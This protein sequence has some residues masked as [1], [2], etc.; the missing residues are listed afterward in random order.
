VSNALQSIQADPAS[1]LG[2]GENSEPHV[3]VLGAGLGGM[4]AAIALRRRGWRVTVIEKE[5]SPWHRVGESFD[6]ETPV[7]LEQLGLN[8]EELRE[9]DVLALKPAVI[10]WSD[11]SHRWNEAWLIPDPRYFRLIRR[12]PNTYHGNRHQLDHLLS[13]MMQAE[14]CRLVTERVRKVHMQGQTVEK[15]ELEGGEQLQAPFYIDASGRARLIMRAA[16]VRTTAQGEKMVSLWRRQRHHYD[17]KGTRLYLVDVGEQVFWT[18]N[19]HVG[20]EITDIGMVLPATLYRSLAS[21]GLE[22]NGDG[23]DTKEAEDVYWKLLEKVKL[24]SDFADQS[25]TAGPLQ[26]CSFQN[27]MA[28]RAAGDNWLAVGEAAYVID[29]ISSGGTTIALRSGKFAARILDEALSKG[30]TQVPERDRHFFH[31]RLSLQV[32]F[33]NSALDDLFRFRRLGYR[34]GMPIYVRLLTWPQFHI[35][36]I[37]SAFDLRSRFGLLV[38][39]LLRVMVGDGVRG[40]LYILRT[41]Y[42][43][44]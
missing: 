5:P 42:R 36:R 1:Y 6:W 29:P 12:N 34:I 30:Q 32:R 24:L 22:G 7:L 38:L 9:R 13:E 23:P 21:G 15:I 41:I 18:W 33:V 26:V 31:Q 37:G 16:G 35:N 40:F 14:G 27:T 25:R 28:E 4:A 20:A 43:S 2:S 39:R 19:I 17:G 8:L 10:L 11:T 44:K 3:L